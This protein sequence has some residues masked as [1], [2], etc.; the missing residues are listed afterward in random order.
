[1]TDCA[2]AQSADMA[3]SGSVSNG[4][5]LGL[6]RIHGERFLTDRGVLCFKGSKVELVL[7]SKETE[8]R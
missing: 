8:N 3:S 5:T 6:F 4:F 1:M 2:C 7:L